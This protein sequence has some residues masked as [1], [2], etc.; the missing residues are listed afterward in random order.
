M[1]AGVL[2]AISPAANAMGSTPRSAG[3][4]SAVGGSTLVQAIAFRMD[5]PVPA[6]DDDSG[7]DG[8]STTDGSGSGGSGGFGGGGSGTG[9]GADG[10]SQGDGSSQEDGF[11]QGGG[12]G[13]GYSDNSCC[14]TLS[15]LT[16]AIA[17]YDVVL[18][19]MNGL[20][21]HETY[22]AEITGVISKVAGNVFW[23]SYSRQ[24]VSH[25]G[26]TDVI[27]AL[28]RRTAGVADQSLTL[29]SANT[30]VAS[31]SCGLNDF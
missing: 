11:G 16:T 25:K 3:A 15:E 31:V 17:C 29:A 27:D 4:L 21:R 9:T 8:G 20:K 7:A 19:Y 2:L 12:S 18:S 28:D 22:N 1:S 30:F 13:Q 10:S 23:D 6:D 5:D 24:W 26:F 14:A